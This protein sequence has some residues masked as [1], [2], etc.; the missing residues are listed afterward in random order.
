MLRSVIGLGAA[1]CAAFIMASGCSAAGDNELEGKGSGSGS[2]NGSSNASS[3]SGLGE[4]PTGGFNGEE[5]GSETF[6]N[7]VP[8]SM[9]I[10]FDK[11][12]SMSEAVGGPT[13]YNASAQAI[14]AMTGAATPDSEMGLLAFPEGAFRRHAVARLRAGS[15]LR[16]VVAAVPSGARRLGLS[17]CRAERACSDRA[18]VV[19]RR[20]D[21]S[22]PQFEPA[23]RQHA[24]AVRV[25]PRLPD[26]GGARGDRAEVCAADDRR[27]ALCGFTGRAALA[28]DG[29]QLWHAGG[30]RGRG[31]GG[32]AT[33]HRHIRHRLAGQ[34]ARRGFPVA[35]R[36]QRQHAQ[37]SQ[38][39]CG[40]R[41]TATTRSTARI[42]KPSSK[43]CSAPSPV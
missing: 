33:G 11:S 15:L 9:L 5:C 3:G 34:R 35:A 28:G 21:R 27:R 10:V 1:L 38:L 31:G 14:A 8:G 16:D 37:R 32:V 13:K 12:G 18:A 36:P 29:R 2:G 4:N 39:Q 42:F 22:V 17:G 26:P 43:R 41:A 40:A 6:G 25:A 20:A 24:D 7:Q 19:Q 23:Q 30:H